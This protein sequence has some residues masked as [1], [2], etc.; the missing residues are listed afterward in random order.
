MSS[1]AT[2]IRTLTQWAN[3]IDNVVLNATGNNV[4]Q[5]ARGRTAYWDD[6]LGIVIIRNPNAADGGTAFRPQQGR[7]Y[8]DDLQ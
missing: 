4:R 6:E 8:F 7:Q 5:L 3:H 2:G 1:T